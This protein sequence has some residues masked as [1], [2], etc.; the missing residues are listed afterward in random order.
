MLR[1]KQDLGTTIVIASQS[2]VVNLKVSPWKGANNILTWYDVSWKDAPRAM[3]IRLHRNYEVTVRMQETSFRSLWN[4]LKYAERIEDH[5]RSE[6]DEKL[7]HEAQVAEVQYADSAGSKEFPSE[8]IRGARALVFERSAVVLDRVGERKIHRGYRLA[9]VTDPQNK[10]L[11]CV[12]HDVCKREPLFFEFMVDAAAPGTAAMLVRIPEESKRCKILL[13][14]TDIRARQDLY[15]AL[16]GIA[17][18][19]DGTILG[20][21]VLTGMNLELATQTGGVMQAVPAAL[22]ALKWQRLGITSRFSDLPNGR[23]SST[24]RSDSLRIVARHAAGCFT[25]RLNLSQGELL[26]R[27][28][29]EALPVIQILRNAQDDLSMAI[30]SRNLDPNIADGLTQLDQL[31]RQHATVRTYSF[32]TYDD[33]HAFQSAITGCT[34]RYDGPVAT[35]SIARRRSLVPIHKK[36]EASRARVQILQRD[37]TVQVLAFTEDFSHTDALCFQ[38]SSTDVIETSKGDG[39]GKKW[40][41]KFADAKF[42]LPRIPENGN[43]EGAPPEGGLARI[44]RRFLDI[45]SLEHAEEHDDITVGFD[46]QEGESVI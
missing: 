8:K 11:A 1:G 3:T 25:D 17:V 12:S 33:L 39:K 18:G 42:S 35:L 14:F 37:S 15:D 29:C 21:M 10:S 27:L 24:V 45:E 20:K 31:M 16:C 41:S 22:R 26:V 32:A 7:I 40:S 4:L 2:D 44:R 13:V 9:L 36:W 23:Q 46:T 34:V 43:N 19:P 6:K 30:D 5:L 38:V 28:P